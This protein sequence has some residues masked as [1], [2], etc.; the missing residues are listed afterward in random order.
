M[1]SPLAFVHE[2]A[3][4]GNNVTIGPW[5]YI[6]ADVEI[7]DDTEVASHV[8]IKGRTKIGKGNRIFQ[9]VSIGEENQDK[10]YAGE[11]TETIIG[12]NNIFREC[13]TVHRGT[14]QD[15]GKTV[16]GSNNLFMAYVHIAHDCVLG[17]NIIL[18]NYV[19]LAGHVHVE[20]WAIAGAMSGYHQFCRVG[21]HSF[22][23]AGSIVLKDIP[24]YVMARH[25]EAFGM[26]YE[27]LK[28]RGFDKPAI[29]SLRKAYKT[30]YR[31][32]FTTE[33]ALPVLAEQGKESPAVQV[34]VD[35][36]AKSSRGIVR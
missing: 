1:I 18:A 12:D 14:T 33:E 28:R 32:G 4:I 2:N 8:V 3:R 27:G 21:A 17:D 16:V 13:V 36:L 7:G 10:K 34:I 26:N 9:F 15:Q 23:A 5:S 6:D 30:L 31:E 20:D 22:T 25:N 29:Q 24:P 19:G 35:Y 11:P